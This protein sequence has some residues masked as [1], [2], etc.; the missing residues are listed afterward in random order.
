M[1]WSN[2]SLSEFELRPTVYAFEVYFDGWKKWT[3]TVWDVG[4]YFP[5]EVHLKDNTVFGSI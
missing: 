2:N 3:V 4:N 1:P 5:N